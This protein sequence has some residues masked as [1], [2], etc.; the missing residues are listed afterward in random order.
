MGEIQLSLS[1]GCSILDVEDQSADMEGWYLRAITSLQ[2]A[3]K[4]GSICG[5]RTR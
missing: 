1:V 2:E 4:R 5:N 3:Q